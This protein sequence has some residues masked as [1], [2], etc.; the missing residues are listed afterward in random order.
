MQIVKILT[1]KSLNYVNNIYFYNSIYK[2]FHL[3]SEDL[4][5]H[6][7]VLDADVQAPQPEVLILIEES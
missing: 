3:E 2:N 6:R 7:S 1:M 4:Q 5:Q